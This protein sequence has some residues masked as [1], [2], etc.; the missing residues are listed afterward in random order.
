MMT[1]NHLLHEYDRFRTGKKESCSRCNAQRAFA[2]AF[3][4][5]INVG[6]PSRY[7]TMHFLWLDQQ[8]EQRP[9]GFIC[10]QCIDQLIGEGRIEAYFSDM[11]GPVPDLSEK[12]A[13]VAYALGVRRMQ[14][15]LRLPANEDGEVMP[16]SL[17]RLPL[18]LVPKHR[19]RMVKQVELVTGFSAGSTIETDP[20]GAGRRDA[21]VRAALGLPFDTDI[22][23]TA[24][25]WARKRSQRKERDREINEMMMSAL[26]GQ[27]DY[28]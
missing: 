26:A 4:E 24:K 19:S 21:L 16:V 25:Q 3:D 9:T 11:N 27:D 5:E 17:S 10:D 7:D 1:E 28:E 18:S 22:D 13:A 2:F 23:D 20:E 15:I 8:P 12:G 6:C 14:A